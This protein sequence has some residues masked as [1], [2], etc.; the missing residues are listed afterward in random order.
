LAEA[1]KA[2]NSGKNPWFLAEFA[3]NHPLIPDDAEGHV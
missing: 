1:L 3:F 2:L